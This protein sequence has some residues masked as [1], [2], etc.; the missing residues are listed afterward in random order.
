MFSPPTRTRPT[1][2]ER[3]RRL[4]RAR[5]EAADRRGLWIGWGLPA[6]GVVLLCEL[7]YFFF[8]AETQGG[9]SV[10]GVVVAAA[11]GFLAMC[12]RVV[13]EHLFGRPDTIGSPFPVMAIASAAVMVVALLVLTVAG[14]A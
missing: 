5:M 11:L 7:L 9:T 12:A 3:Y 2:N 4:R 14:L 10:F 1:K 8:I 6:A 13:Q